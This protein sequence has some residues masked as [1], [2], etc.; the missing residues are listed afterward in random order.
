MLRGKATPFQ[1]FSAG[2]LGAMIGFMPGFSQAAGLIIALVLLL[3]ILNANLALAALTGAAAKLLS[4]ALMPVSFACG[5]WLLD[6]PFSGLFQWMINA[7]VLALFGFEYYVVTGGLLL[8]V[9]L[10]LLSGWGVVRAMT[11]YRKKMAGLEKNSERFQ[12]YNSKK[13]VKALKFVLIGGGKGKLTYEDLLTKK[14]GNPIRPL[15]VVF[16]VLVGV[17]LVIV[18]LFASGPIVTS[19]LQSGLERANGATVDLANADLDLKNQRLTIEGL[20]MADPNALDTD[21]FRAKKLEAEVSGVNLLRKRLQLNR[22]VISDASHGEKRST[23]GKLVGPPPQPTEE[24]KPPNTKGIEDYIKNA[25][26]WKE[27]LAQVRRWIEKLSGP[28]EEKTATPEQ[29]NETLRE[30]LARQVSELGYARVKA[31]HL[32][33]GS[34][35]LTVSELLADGVRTPE[36]PNETLSITASNL[37]TQPALLGKAPYVKIK[38]SKDTLDF[39]TWL[40]AYETAARP[41]TVQLDYRGLPTDVIAKDLV[42]DGTQPVQG[43]T[44]D[45]AAKGTLDTLKGVTID[46]PMQATLHNATITIPGGKATQVQQFILPIG[47]TGPLDNPRIKVDAK[48]LTDALVK[49]GVNQAVGELKGKAGELLEKELGNKAGEQ[50]KSLLNGLLN[51]TKK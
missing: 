40:G 8:G 1:L 6:G 14:I 3:I 46:L 2:V 23:P 38:S 39:E 17:L 49:A 24:P 18:Y 21:L 35:T 22:V 9:I 34:P 43:G 48:Q 7:P 26:V 20:A 37:S 25:K 27:R 44:I 42:I 47:L 19:E 31:N 33:E 41:S 45:V 30:R 32:I 36:L 50:G 29:K 12:K 16:A 51:R 4:L 10:G 15:G 5:R 13:W 28:K 11:A